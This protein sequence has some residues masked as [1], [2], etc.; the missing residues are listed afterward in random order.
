MNKTALIVDDEEDIGMMVSIILNKAGVRA[1]CCKR[2]SKAM[3][4]VEKQRF[5]YYY[6]DLSLPDG[7]GFDLIPLIQQNDRDAII[8]IISAFDDDV[9][10]SRAKDLEVRA[11]IKKPFTRLDILSVLLD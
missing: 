1:T 3:S 7:T 2:V 8:V 4:L 6:L 10:T 9:E 5:D 11:F